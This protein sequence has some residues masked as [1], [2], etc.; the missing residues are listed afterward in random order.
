V[1]ASRKRAPAPEISTGERRRFEW[2]TEELRAYSWLSLVLH[3]AAAWAV[4]AMLV[5]SAL[6]AGIDVPMVLAG[7]ASIGIALATGLFAAGLA[8]GLAA[9]LCAL[10]AALAA[11]VRWIWLRFGRRTAAFVPVLLLSGPVGW[12]LA[13]PPMTKHFGARLIM[14]GG[15]VVAM[16]TI[17]AAGRSRRRWIRLGG[18]AC[19][20]G[21]AIF[22]DLMVP[23]TFYPEVHDLNCLITVMAGLLAARPLQRKAVAVPGTRLIAALVAGLGFSAALM[24]VADQMA[25]GWRRES[26]A[27]ARYATRLLA[28]TRAMADLDADGFSPL[29]WGGDCDDFNDRRFPLATDRPG[30]GDRNCNGIDPPANPTDAQRG[31]APAAG[32]P[33]AAPDGIDLALLITVDCMRGDAVAQAMPHLVERSARG[34]YFERMYAGGTRTAASMPLIATGGTGGTPIGERL[35]AAGVSSSLVLGV[36]YPTLVDRIGAGVDEVVLDKDQM[37]ISAVEVTARALNHLRKVTVDGKRHFV[38]VHY[39]DAHAP[40]AEAMPP[41][42]S[43]GVRA[44]R[45][46]YLAGLRQID[47]EIGDLLDAL[48]RRGTLERAMVIV[49]A[50]HGEAFGEHG[51]VYHNVSGYEALTHIPALLLAPGLKPARYPNL[52]SHRDI[53]PTLLGAFGLVGR[54]PDA[55]LWGRSWLRLRAAPTAPLH[56]FVAIRTH[57]FTSGPVAIS[58]MM[59]LVESHYKLVKALDEDHLYELYDLEA[60]PGERVDLVF[61]QTGLRETMERELDTFR[62]LDRWP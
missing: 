5:T 15:F 30:A 11:M 38:W 36:N 24:T 13:I 22:V 53:Y 51:L 33:D 43:A 39:F 4:T 48:E 1:F 41:T 6:A 35:R 49:T 10:L 32:D 21:A 27:R 28:L 55:E 46:Y 23:N 3:D 25:P 61:T 7:G 14:V 20:G 45:E 59:A 40:S 17:V 57:R 37:W 18:A 2:N 19:V 16:V 12:L 50:D 8:A 52:A 34:V 62:D 60:D 44:A 42:T 9:P 56:R 54:T 47:R 58:P 26:A 29:A 31:L